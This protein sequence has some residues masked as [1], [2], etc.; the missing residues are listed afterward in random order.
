MKAVNLSPR[1]RKLEAMVGGLTRGIRGEVGQT[2]VKLALGKH[3]V[4]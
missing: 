2:G 3:L 1:K 4:G